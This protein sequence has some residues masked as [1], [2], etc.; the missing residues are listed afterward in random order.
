MNGSLNEVRVDQRQHALRDALYIR[1]AVISRIC[2]YLDQEDAQ[3]AA[4]D[5]ICDALQ[6]ILEAVAGELRLL[7]GVGADRVTTLALKP[8][9]ESPPEKQAATASSASMKACQNALVQVGTHRGLHSDAR[10]LMLQMCTT[11]L[12]NLRIAEPAATMEPAAVPDE[13]RR[14]GTAERVTWKDTVHGVVSKTAVSA[15]DFV[16]HAC[17][18]VKDTPG[19]IK[20][21]WPW[22]RSNPAEVARL[23]SEPPRVLD[24]LKR[25]PLRTTVGV[26]RKD[27]DRKRQIDSL[28]A[29]LRLCI[30][31]ICTDFCQW[32]LRRMHLLLKFPSRCFRP[33]PVN[34]VFQGGGPKGIAYIG[35]L[36]HLEQHGLDM[37]RIRRV[38][39]ASAG[40][41]NA[42]PL[43]VGYTTAELKLILSGIRMEEWLDEPE[44]RQ[45]LFHWKDAVGQRSVVELLTNAVVGRRERL[46]KCGDAI[47]KH[48]GT[49]DRL[50]CLRTD[51]MFPPLDCVR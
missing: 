31:Q 44:L 40:A 7:H 10:A 21:T 3:A 16:Q 20:S 5:S 36:E 1:D 11:L 45:E 48:H 33:H 2:T 19:R 35:V 14:S 9:I 51:A 26:I 4:V 50:R 32:R 25:D 18:M 46:R 41:I 24:D 42:L 28:R 22:L 12:E 37:R 39:G 34:L 13:N 29:R 27:Q 15:V 6:L 49:V 17:T 8:G 47:S 43:A 23:V 30:Q 38:A